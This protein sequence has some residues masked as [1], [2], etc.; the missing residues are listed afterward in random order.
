MADTFSMDEFAARFA[1]VRSSLIGFAERNMSQALCKIIPPE[2]VVQE[3]YLKAA[4]RL[5]DFA[6]SD[7]E[8]AFEREVLSLVDENERKHCPGARES[9]GRVDIDM[10]GFSD[11]SRIRMAPSDPYAS[12]HRVL[13]DLSDEE[14]EIVELRHFKGLSMIA[15]AK[16][17]RISPATAQARYLKAMTKLKDVMGGGP[18][19]S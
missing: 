18:S 12:L 14:R 16:T 1:R 11:S 8:S 15:C 4:R 17:L 9:E 10:S 2:Q 5:E 19:R 7:Y 3:A 13:R 6:G